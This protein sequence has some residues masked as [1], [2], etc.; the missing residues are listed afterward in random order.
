[1]PQTLH[2]EHCDVDLDARTV[3]RRSASTPLTEVEAKMLQYLAEHLSED[4]TRGELLQHVW[5]YS[6]N[7]R[8]RAVDQ[9]VKRLRPKIEADPA[10]PKHLISVYGVGYRLVVAAKES[11]A[12]PIAPCQIPRL[13]TGTF[14]REDAL[15]DLELYVAEHPLVCI[16]GPP[17]EGKSHLAC[18]FAHYWRRILSPPGGVW[19]VPCEN[20]TTADELAEALV[21]GLGLVLKDDPTL[22]GVR[23]CVD[24]RGE[25]LIILDNADGLTEA[26]P[27]A[28]SELMHADAAKWLLTTRAH[29][30]LEAQYLDL[31]PLPEDAALALFRARARWVQPSVDWPD[32]ECKALVA[33]V[34]YNALAIT[35]A[36]PRTRAL[37]PKALASRLNADLG[38]LSISSEA[39]HSRHGSLDRAISASWRLL[40]AEHQE[41]LAALST[42]ANT[43]TFEAAEAVIDGDAIASVL[44]LCDLSL[45]LPTLEPGR[46]AFR[47]PVLVRAFASRQLPSTVDQ[48]RA[49]LCR[50]LATEIHKTWAT[51]AAFG[52]STAPK[53][54]RYE[55]DLQRHLNDPTWAGPFLVALASLAEVRGDNYSEARYLRQFLDGEHEETITVYAKIRAAQNPLIHRDQDSRTKAL[56]MLG[57][58]AEHAVVTQFHHL[59]QKCRFSLPAVEAT[60]ATADTVLQV[61]LT[62]GEPAW[63]IAGHLVRGR[64]YGVTGDLFQA[65]ADFHVARE[66]CDD[67]G[68]HELASF[69]EYSLGYCALELME[70][71]TARW[72][73]N[74][75]ATL[76]AEQHDPRASGIGALTALADMVDERYHAARETLEHSAK[77]LDSVS[78]RWAAEDTFNLGRIALFEG[79]FEEAAARLR[80]A[81]DRSVRWGNR[82][83][84]AAATLAG[85]LAALGDRSAPVHA[86]LRDTPDWHPS[87]VAAR[88]ILESDLSTEPLSG[89]S[90]IETLFAQRLL[91]RW[92]TRSQTR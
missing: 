39:P 79:D 28:M 63:M 24:R 4:V 77:K 54:A 11:D 81:V 55:A 12:Q 67:W 38:I 20:L 35:L 66:A 73:F 25:A 83:A 16:V 41:S 23:D 60:R 27:A 49:K 42:F 76:M 26:L 2:F 30:F 62:A 13:P 3:K 14:G 1:M 57:D 88:R 61:A 6:P 7:V 75:A 64:F 46:D 48:A 85:T 34:D 29:P 36:A 80:E 18:A 31:Q 9:T 91:E 51:P 43:F 19:V 70:L 22:A 21:R 15:D 44:S 33:A 52:W 71:D 53:L 74:A 56:R 45:V 32:S 87:V 65:R 78:H 68:E 37:G 17:G 86:L 82:H 50:Y 90:A 89:P 92:L 84:A 10:N 5:G 8:S 59:R 47:V 58:A 40:S 69:C 72:H